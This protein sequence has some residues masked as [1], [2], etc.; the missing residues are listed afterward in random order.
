MVPLHGR[1]VKGTGEQEGFLLCEIQ[2]RVPD[3]GVGDFLKYTLSSSLIIVAYVEHGFAY[4]LK[5]TM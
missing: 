5:I 3:I 2:I 1:L 4:M